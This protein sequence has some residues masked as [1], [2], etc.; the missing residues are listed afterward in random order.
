LEKIGKKITSQNPSHF[1]LAI[2]ETADRFRKADLRLTRR[3][4][5]A[6][7]HAAVVQ[8]EIKNQNALIPDIQ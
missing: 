8:I 6:K 2:R 3:R 5:A 1:C 4:A 7:L